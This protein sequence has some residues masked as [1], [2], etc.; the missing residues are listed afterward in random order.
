MSLKALH[1][2]FVISSVLLA[3]GFAAWLLNEYFRNGQSVG[4][5]AGGVASVVSGVALVLYGK[6]VLEKL[7]KISFL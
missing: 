2:V 7:K 6:F 4:Y 3:F 1:I 5:L